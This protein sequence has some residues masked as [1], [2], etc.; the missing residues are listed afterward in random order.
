[1]IFIYGTKI[2][3]AITKSVKQNYYPYNDAISTFI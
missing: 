2:I 1:M 3:L